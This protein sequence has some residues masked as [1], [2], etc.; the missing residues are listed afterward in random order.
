M[1]LLPARPADD[2]RRNFKQ[3]CYGRSAVYKKIRSFYKKY[4]TDYQKNIHHKA[5]NLRVFRNRGT[6]KQDPITLCNKKSCRLIHYPTFQRD[7]E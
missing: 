6:K 5:V 1:S 7:D 3:L 4:E 2:Y